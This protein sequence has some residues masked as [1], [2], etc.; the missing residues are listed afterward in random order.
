MADDYHIDLEQFSLE[1]FRHILETRDLQPG[2]MILKE[3]LAERFQILESMG[4]SNLKELE[5][6][7]ETKKRME[8][9]AQESGL[10]NDYL[11]ILRR[12][13]SSYVP[14]PFN[15]EKIPEVN[16]EYIERLAASGIKNTKHLFERAKFKDGRAELSRLVDVPDDDLLELVKLS[17]LARIWGVGPL[18]ARLLYEAGVDTIEEFLKCS[19]KE[20]S[21]TL[22]AINNE[23]HYTPIM[24]TAK[25]IEYCIELAKYLPRVVEY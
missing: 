3:Q 17:D 11:V 6:V 10:P 9:F 25:D 4:I 14:K 13:V 5:A 24:P 1:H 16:P 21:E 23:E 19:L 22:H 8:K 2:R 20:L 7:L 12:E 18:F 15:L